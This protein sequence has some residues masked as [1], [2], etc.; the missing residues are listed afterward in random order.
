MVEI[1]ESERPRDT[2]F[3]KLMREEPGARAEGI[4]VWLLNDDQI[5]ALAGPSGLRRE[6]R[7]GVPRVMTDEGMMGAFSFENSE[8]VGGTEYTS[9]HEVRVLAR[10]AGEKNDLLIGFRDTEFSAGGGMTNRVVQTNVQFGVRVQ[11]PP[12]ERA[13]IV[14]ERENGKAPLLI[15][16][17]T[18][19]LKAD[20]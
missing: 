1:I 13:I 18:R 5:E 6:E 12:Q 7:V 17:Q 15:S 3:T 11:L 8:V 14:V 2:V 9:G 20:R 19:F 16:V 10:R 4:R